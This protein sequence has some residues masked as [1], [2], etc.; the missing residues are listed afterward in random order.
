MNMFAALVESMQ[1]VLK[2][3]RIKGRATGHN[4]RNVTYTVHSAV[5]A[6][7]R[8][9]RHVFNSTTYT[10]MPGLSLITPLKTLVCD[11]ASRVV[12]TMVSELKVNDA[13]ANIVE[14][15]MQTCVLL[16]TTPI[17]DSGLVTWLHDPLRPCR[18]VALKGTN[19]N[20]LVQCQTNYAE[21]KHLLCLF[22]QYVANVLG[23]STKVGLEHLTVPQ[24]SETDL[25]PLVPLITS[26]SKVV[27]LPDRCESERSKSPDLNLEN[28][29]WHLQTSKVL[30]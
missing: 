24:L 13:A 3:T 29:L 14:L 9:L 19:G 7:E 20:L 1:D 8:R 22:Y 17:L 12:T 25:L 26:L 6:N 15:F 28:H 5:N 23:W 2:R 4:T 16:Q 27:G 21:P 30:G 10:I 18:S 11:A